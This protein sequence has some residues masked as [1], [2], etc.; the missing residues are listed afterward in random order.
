MYISGTMCASS[1]HFLWCIIMNVVT[2]VNV[3]V[4][5]GI[6][7]GGICMKKSADAPADYSIGFRTS[8]AMSNSKAWSFANKKCGSAW[9][10]IGSICFIS[11]VAAA[12]LLSDYSF[13]QPA[14]LI[15]L[16]VSAIASTAAVEVK[17][18]NISDTDK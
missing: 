5:L 7:L 17:L 6:M 12:F 11:T 18:K 1:P 10:I 8:R 13:V 9:L 15:T 16:G 14:I 3:I 2:I 4:S